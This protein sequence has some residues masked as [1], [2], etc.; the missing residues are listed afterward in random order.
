MQPTTQDQ[1]DITDAEASTLI[2]IFY[3][4]TGRIYSLISQINRGAWQERIVTQEK[5]QRS[6]TLHKGNIGFTRAL[7]SEFSTAEGED[8]TR[9]IQT[10]K[11]PFDEIVLNLL[12]ALGITPKIVLPN[13]VFSHIDILSGSITLQNYKMIS[14]LFP[15]LKQNPKMFIKELQALDILL[16]RIQE[17]KQK[18]RKTPEENRLLSSLDAQKNMLQKLSKEQ[19]DIIETISSMYNFF[20]SGIGF[21][22][23]MDNGAILSGQLKPDNLIDSEEIVFTNFGESLPA[24]WNILGVIDYVK[25]DSEFE[26]DNTSP[27]KALSQISGT[28]RGMLSKKDIAGTI[29]PILIYRELVVSENNNGG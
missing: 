29:I 15:I 18:K 21:E 20:P 1:T 19:Q 8:I 2:D 14:N 17:L 11:A 9:N 25:S 22:L 24:K 16:P 3:K 5:K 6:D 13:K 4:D 10:K 23:S 12:E 26:E 27:I 7:G 28:I